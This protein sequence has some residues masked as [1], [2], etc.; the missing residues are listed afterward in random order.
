MSDIILRSN[1]IPVYGFLS[2]IAVDGLPA[3]GDP[4]LKILD[5][6]AGGPVPPAALFAQHG[7]EAFGIDV[8]EAQLALAKEFCAAQGIDVDLR[9]GDM[10]ALPFGDESFDYVFEQYAMCH[11]SKTDTVKAVSEMRRVLKPGGTAFLGVISTDSWPKSFFGEE[12]VPGEFWMM[13]DGE[14]AR[15]SM[16]TDAEAEALVAGWKM[17]VKTKQVQYLRDHALEISLDEWMDLLDEQTGCCTQE[18]W[19]ARYEDRVNAFY[20]VHLYFTLEKNEK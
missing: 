17:T 14:V 12:K 8:S 2:R 1:A 9:Q 6:G 15:H 18:E 20:Y 10:R 16:F 13:E 3:E 4:R 5:C 11:L 7:F 19:Q